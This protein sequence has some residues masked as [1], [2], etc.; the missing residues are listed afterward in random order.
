MNDSEKTKGNSWRNPN[1]KL[2]SEMSHDLKT[3]INI[4]YSSIQL[5]D[6]YKDKLDAESYREKAIKQMDII[7][8]NCYRVMRM[9]NNLIDLSCHD[10][11]F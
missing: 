9:T 6:S 2:F 1:I 3:P 8:Q 5:M 4:I 10:S 7:R 11:G